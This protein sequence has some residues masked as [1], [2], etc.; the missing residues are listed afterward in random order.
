MAYASGDNL[1]TGPLGHSDK[2]YQSDGCLDSGVEGIP[3]KG[4]QEEELISSTGG[5]RTTS[6]SKV[7]LSLY[8]AQNLTPS[9]EMATKHVVMLGSEDRNFDAPATPESAN[10][11]GRPPFP[12]TS[13][14]VQSGGIIPTPTTCDYDV[15]K[16]Q[17]RFSASCKDDDGSLQGSAGNLQQVLLEQ[18]G[19]RGGCVVQVLDPS[20]IQVP[21]RGYEIMEQ[22]ARFTLAILFPGF[23]L[24]LPPKKWFGDN[25][26]PNFLEDRTL[27]LQAFINNITGHKDVC[28][29]PPV[30][31]FFC[32]DDPPGPHDSLEESRSL[33]EA[34]EEQLYNTK[35]L[36]QERDAEISILTEERDMYKCQTEALQ[37]ALRVERTLNSR[38]RQTPISPPSSDTSLAE[39][40]QPMEGDGQPPERPHATKTSEKPS[41]DDPSRATSPESG[42]GEGTVTTPTPETPEGGAT[43]LPVPSEQN[44]TKASDVQA[45][46]S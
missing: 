16:E 22:R 38:I 26:D 36:L 37:R 31:D 11:T 6:L 45:V 41:A 24:A 28:N 42:I 23:R 43:L 27:G 19:E 13:T 2:H 34:L 5:R 17:V 29:S 35:K 8:N 15:G 9:P 4:G 40:D 10:S 3:E 14:P 20:E 46:S 7:P 18:S 33:C 21:I 39:C 1:S 44:V 12:L 30:R 25:F 32:F